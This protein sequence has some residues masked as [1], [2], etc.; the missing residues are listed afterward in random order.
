MN[1]MKK[2][3]VLPVAALALMAMLAYGVGQ[4]KADEQFKNHPLVQFIAERFDLDEEEVLTA[5]EDFQEQRHEQVGVQFENRLTQAVLDGKLTEDQREMILQKH[6]EMR[7]EQESNWAAL[8]EMSAD[9][10][11]DEIMV[12][13]EELKSWAEENGIDLSYFNMGIGRGSRMHGMSGEFGADW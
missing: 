4:V 5:M 12:R 1:R 9:E 7:A 10:R 6:E 3:I 11:R 13:H 8:R 2:T